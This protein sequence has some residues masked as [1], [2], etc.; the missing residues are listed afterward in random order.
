MRRVGPQITYS[1][2]GYLS[3]RPVG[4]DWLLARRF[5]GHHVRNIGGLEKK[6]KKA[7]RVPGTA[8]VIDK[9]A[10]SCTKVRLFPDQ[11]EFKVP[12]M[13]L[14]DPTRFIKAL[15]VDLRV[16]FSPIAFRGYTAVNERVA[17]FDS[18]IIRSNAGM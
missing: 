16:C 9:T 13:S 4:C 2:F 1:D 3:F 11:R 5:L 8:L 10:H 6:H 12:T 7:A 17:V 14:A 18:E 15:Q